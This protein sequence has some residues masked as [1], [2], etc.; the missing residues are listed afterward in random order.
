VT[1]ALLLNRKAGVG[2]TERLSSY[3]FDELAN[4]SIPYE[5]IEGDSPD[6]VI[7]KVRGR[8]S[9]FSAVV[10]VGGDGS[11]HTAAQ[12]AYESGLPLGVIASGSGDD[13]ARACGLPHGRTYDATKKSVDHF[14]RAYLADDK[15]L[16]DSIRLRTADNIEHTIMAVMSAG[17]DSRVNSNSAKMTQ[18]KG[19]FRYV[20]ALLKTLGSFKPID[21]HWKFNGEEK[22]FQA[23]VVVI[24]NGSMF[25]GGMKVCPAA[26]IKDGEFDLLVVNKISVATLLRIFPRIFKGSHVTHPKVTELRGQKLWI[27][28]PTEQAWGDGEYLGLTPM[29]LE[30]KPDSIQVYGVRL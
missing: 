24:G 30:I 27:D 4:K 1:V 14:I 2:R 20:A 5:L 13:I 15:T 7:A 8:I 17:F 29:E 21:Y 16:V 28:A 18:L 19:T 26:H 25:G 3:L 10:S 6:D 9:E 23:M 12:I 22:K 11:A